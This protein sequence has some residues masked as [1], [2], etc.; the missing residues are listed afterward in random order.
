[1]KHFESISI[2]KQILKEVV[3]DCCNKP[4]IN[5]E[6]GIE[7]M[8]LHASWGFMSNKDLESWEAQ[9]CEECVDQKFRDIKFKKTD[10]I[11][12]RVGQ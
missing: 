3:C 5:T 2:V 7:Y 10:Y 8:T 9:V 1:M 12:G 4:C 11:T 6:Y